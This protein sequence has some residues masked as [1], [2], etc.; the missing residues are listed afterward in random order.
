[1]LLG[2][3]GVAFATDLKSVV[4]YSVSNMAPMWTH[5]SSSSM[6]MV[7]ATAGGGVVVNDASQGLVSL[8]PNGNPTT[9][10]GTV[11]STLPTITPWSLGNWIG[12]LSGSLAEFSGPS[13][14]VALSDWPE[15][16]GNPEAQNAPHKPAFSHFVV[17][18]PGPQYSMS[19]F[20]SQMTSSGFLPPRKADHLFRL[21]QD[22][23]VKTWL[24]D[25]QNRLDAMGFIGHSI[26]VQDSSGNVFSVGLQFADKGLVKAGSYTFSIPV[27]RVNSVATNAKV[28]FFASCKIGDVFNSLWGI[29][30][31]TK[32]RALI[33]PSTPIQNTNLLNGAIA[34]LSIATALAEGKTVSQAVQL[35]N[36]AVAASFGTDRWTVIGDLNAK[37]AP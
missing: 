23:S 11:T 5:S 4:A 12:A 30:S 7:A 19:F 14:D 8:D 9:F 36:D 25:A 10:P 33:V 28:L 27:V 17:E 20:R 32:G 29:D 13:T 21:G 18:D 24:S 6:D 37:I 2:E 22:A 1:M 26:E 34:W 3:N 16:E 31:N 15:P 35:G